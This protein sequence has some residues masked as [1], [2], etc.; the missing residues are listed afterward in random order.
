MKFNKTIDQKPYVPDKN[1]IPIS[2]SKKSS[3]LVETR[4]PLKRIRKKS[5]PDRLDTRTQT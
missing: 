5:Y 1:R 4:I 2:K 3:F